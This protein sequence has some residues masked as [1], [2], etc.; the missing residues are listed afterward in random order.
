MSAQDNKAVVEG[1]LDAW[2]RSDFEAIEN[3]L[4]ADFV[5]NNPPPI[6]GIGR[7]RS[8]MLG[9]M[10][11]LRQGFPDSQAEVLNVIAATRS[12]S[13]TAFPVRTKESSSAFRPQ[14]VRRR[15]SSFTYSE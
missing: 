9:V 11:Y 1:M 5:N 4:S 7:D 14:V 2:N 8:G 10:R 15:G 3:I 13:T 6:P 12:S